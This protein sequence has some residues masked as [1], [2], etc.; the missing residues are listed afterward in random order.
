MQF[1]S[2]YRNGN[3][4]K[5]SLRSFQHSFPRMFHSDDQRSTG[6]SNF[7][8]IVGHFVNEKTSLSLM[9]ISLNQRSIYPFKFTRVKPTVTRFYCSYRET[10]K[11]TDGQRSWS[12]MQCLPATSFKNEYLHG[13]GDA[14][15]RNCVEF[16]VNAHLSWKSRDH[17]ERRWMDVYPRRVD[18]NLGN[19]EERNKG[20]TG[21]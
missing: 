9:Q 16:I 4:L 7:F 3:N 2:C 21:K 1:S 12:L 5:C 20:E 10:I 14:A 13:L 6:G 15:N 17:N 8:S 19:E 18:E 11:P